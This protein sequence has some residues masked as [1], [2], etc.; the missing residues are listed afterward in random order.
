ML[1]FCTLSQASFL[2]VQKDNLMLKKI[3]SITLL[4]CVF[5]VFTISLF[6]YLVRIDQHI[7]RHIEYHD[8]VMQLRILNKNFNNF[9]L[10]Q[11]TFIN[12]DR[13]N[14]SVNTFES[15]LEFLN[16][17]YEDVSDSKAYKQL[18][19]TTTKLYEMKLYSIEYF[20]SQNSQL[21]HSLHYL[22]DLNMVLLNS[23]KIDQKTAS[24]VNKTFLYLSKFYIN[25]NIETSEIKNNILLLKEALAKNY[26]VE[27]DMFIVHTEI[28]MQHITAFGKIKK[29]LQKASLESALQDLQKYLDNIYNEHIIIEKTIVTLFFI[30]AIIILSLLIFMNRRA[31]AMRDELLGFKTA[32]ENSY[33]SIVITDIDKKITYVNDKVLEET[34]YSREEILGNN[35]NIFKSGTSNPEFYEN[36]RKAL[37]DGDKWEGEFINKRKD[38]SL[39]YE[40]ASIIPVFQNA[41]LVSYLAIKLNI[42]DY[43]EAKR[44]VEYMAYH[45]PLTS[46]PNRSNIENYLQNRLVIASREQAKIALLF[47]DLDRFKNINDTLGHDV[48]DELLVEASRRIKNTL[49]ESDILSRFG[50][51]E[52]VVVI[53]NFHENYF[54]AQICQKI[55]NVFQ[56]PIQT[57]QHL[58]NIT[59]SIGVSVFPDDAK[60][61]TTLFK[62]ADIAMYKAKD[63]GKNT[64]QYYKKELSVVAHKRLD[65]EQALKEAI[66]TDEFYVMY[67]PQYALQSKNIIG[68]EAL[69]RWNSSSLG[70]ITPD[71]FIPV[72]EDIGYILELGLFIF[73]QACLDFIEFQK[74]CHSLEN[75]SINISAVQLYQNRF[76]DDILEIAS[77]TG[78]PTHSIMLEITETHIMKNI[79]HGM[80]LLNE[81]KESGFKISIDDFG[82]GHSSLSYLKLFPI[83]ELKIDKSFIDNVPSDKN[84]VAITKAIMA[85]SKSM[86]YINVAEGI[87]N[88]IQEKFLQENNCFAGQGYYFCKPKTKNDLLN[89]LLTKSR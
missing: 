21:L 78:V 44:E 36:M 51:D 47:I 6:I 34:G 54:I 1:H 55:L 40:K 3:D 39:F 35:P 15:N 75:I 63:E 37:D 66:G 48:G 16:V 79:T 2:R 86:G 49:R 32:I 71:K 67:Q 74:V 42:T 7:Q 5:I 85:L 10:S 18:L 4:L 87:E 8:A 11:A 81:L 84:D 88:E 29:M 17:T 83:S 68:L 65:L 23:R 27:L 70:N 89:F 80:K 24:I 76:I 69:V 30:F 25:S 31:I 9:L 77:E 14:R 61:A 45:D 60:N 82:T 57:K 52:F 38:G 19:K 13:I 22:F 41:K 33:N 12:Y 58:L 26:N 50:G 28:D 72:C 56:N 43:I 46:L 62:Y 53:E 64:Y 73:K 20:K 59:L